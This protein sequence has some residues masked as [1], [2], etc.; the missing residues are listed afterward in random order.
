MGPEERDEL[1]LEEAAALLGLST[2]DLLELL[3]EA[4]VR[5]EKAGGVRL[6]AAEVVA[7]QREREKLRDRNL[8]GLSRLSEEFDEES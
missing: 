2:G 6:R 3:E 8:E 5:V 4:G 7:L 1:S